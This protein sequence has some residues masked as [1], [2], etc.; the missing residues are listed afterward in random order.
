MA[1]VRALKQRTTF[2][3]QS[4]GHNEAKWVG[5]CPT[6][7]EWSSFV[8]ET[9]GPAPPRPS[10]TGVSDGAVPVAITEVV[11]ISARDRYSTGIGELDRVL[12][13][14]LVAGCLVLLG[15]DPG[16]GKSTLLVQALDG[17]A[18]SGRRVLYVSGEESVQQTALRA[19]RLGVRTKE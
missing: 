14:G 11:E 10:A 19:E 6:C 3:C 9:E 13:G 12:G 8:E 1:K 17:I 2:V 5:R 4:C 16:I 7:H 15:G 18:R